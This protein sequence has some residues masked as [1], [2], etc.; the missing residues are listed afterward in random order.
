M[1]Q[2]FE[3]RRSLP[4]SWA[5]GEED[6]HPGRGLTSWLVAVAP[7]WSWVGGGEGAQGVLLRFAS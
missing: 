4:V 1:F 7:L 5:M 3:E 6:A 2:R